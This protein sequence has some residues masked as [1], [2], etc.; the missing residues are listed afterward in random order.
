MH[1]LI[2]EDENFIRQTLAEY[3]ISL[4][5]KVSE[6]ENG[7]QCLDLVA[8]THPDLILMDL[9]M[10]VM[11]GYTALAELKIRNVTTPVII[12]SGSISASNPTLY[13]YDC[14]EKP[15]KLEQISDL[16]KLKL[17]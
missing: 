2:C 9:K 15:Y 12:L 1:I 4:G 17:V 16:I 7:L 10:P 11:D 5:Y 14:I 3:L 8:Q 6:A 13:G